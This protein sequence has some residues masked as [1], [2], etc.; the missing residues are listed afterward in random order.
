MFIL[1]ISIISASL[2]FN[3]LRVKKYSKHDRY[4]YK[5]CSSRRDVMDY[6][7]MN[8]DIISEIEYEA[9]RQLLDTLNK[10]I[11]LYSKDRAA[12]IFN[13]R[14][15]IKYIKNTKD[16]ADS[17][18]KIINC[19]NETINGFRQNLNRNIVATFFAYTPFLLEEIFLRLFSSIL[20]ILIKIGLQKLSSLSNKLMVVNKNFH[21]IDSYRKEFKQN[22]HSYC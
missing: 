7:R 22:N 4:L 9:I 14:R 1:V 8:H 15:F 19:N 2:F 18:K 17:S 10:T 13:F 16:L 12:T 3:F 5:F 6:L 21:D 11:N 20:S